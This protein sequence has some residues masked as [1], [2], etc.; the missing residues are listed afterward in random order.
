MKLCYQE[1]A[2]AQ[3]QHQSMMCYLGKAHAKKLVFAV[4]EKDELKDC[5]C[6]GAHEKKS[7]ERVIT[8]KES[9]FKKFLTED[10]KKSWAPCQKAIR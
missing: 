9:T 3:C 1:Q 5:N 7:L 2:L 8:I 6:S 10:R 4:F